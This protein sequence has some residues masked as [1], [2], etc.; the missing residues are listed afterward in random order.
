MRGLFS[1]L[2]AIMLSVKIPY[3]NTKY[4]RTTDTLIKTLAILQISLDITRVFRL[5]ITQWQIYKKSEI[6]DYTMANIQKISLSEV[7]DFVLGFKFGG[8]ENLL[9]VLM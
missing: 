2:N 3:H 6:V 5:W 7:V 1:I 4:H 9:D 8:G